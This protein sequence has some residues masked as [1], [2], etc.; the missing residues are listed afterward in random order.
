[1]LLIGTSFRRVAVSLIEPIFPARK[2]DQKY[3]LT[4]VDYATRYPKV[5]PPKGM[6]T[7]IAGELKKSIVA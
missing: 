1:M 7:E 5:V 3:I 2:K 4:L 6:K